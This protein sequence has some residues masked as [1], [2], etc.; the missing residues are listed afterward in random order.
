MIW[1]LGPKALGLELWEGFDLELGPLPGNPGS[2][3]GHPRRGGL[4]VPGG[5]SEVVARGPLGSQKP[6]EPPGTPKVCK[7]AAFEA[8]FGGFGLF[9]YI[10]WGSR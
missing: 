8:I 4:E 2:D 3:D 5:G 10:L 1:S 9:F 7:I 6:L